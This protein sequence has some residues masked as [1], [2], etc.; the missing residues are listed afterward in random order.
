VGENGRGNL[1][2]VPTAIE[3]EMRE[4]VSILERGMDWTT[5]RWKESE[6]KATET[7]R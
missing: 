2:E 5:E 4:I 6:R 7:T 1:I 3:L